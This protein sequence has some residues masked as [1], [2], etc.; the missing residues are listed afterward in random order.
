M[1]LG[2][3]W[4]DLLHQG[5]DQFFSAADRYAGDVVD[6]LVRVELGALATGDTHRVE[7]VRLDAQQAEFEN[8]E[9]SYRT[10][11]DYEGIRFDDLV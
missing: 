10:C 11:A 6:R 1:E 3:E 8:L 5:V 4:L 7:D 2:I 9:D